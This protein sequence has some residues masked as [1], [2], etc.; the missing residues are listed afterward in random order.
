MYG[1]CRQSLYIY[2]Y[3]ILINTIYLQV[4]IIQIQSIRNTLATI[5]LI[6][7][8]LFFLLFRPKLIYIFV[9]VLQLVFPCFESHSLIVSSHWRLQFAQPL[10]PRPIERRCSGTCHWKIINHGHPKASLI[11]NVINGRITYVTILILIFS[12]I[13]ILIF[14]NSL[15]INLV[16]GIP[17]P[18]KNMSSSL[19]M[20][21]FPIYG[22]SKKSCSKPPTIHW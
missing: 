22:K 10:W 8:A 12:G 21:T 19:G 3:L 20:M 4:R 17:T 16:G 18:L 5:P 13:N 9:Q 15:L 11:Q 2:E 6:E 14:F 7:A 1:L